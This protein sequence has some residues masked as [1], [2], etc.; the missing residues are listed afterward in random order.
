MSYPEMTRYDMN[1]IVFTCTLF[2]CLHKCDSLQLMKPPV[3]DIPGGCC[4]IMNN[5]LLLCYCSFSNQQDV[6]VQ[7]YIVI[8]YFGYSKQTEIVKTEKGTESLQMRLIWKEMKEW[9]KHWS[10]GRFFLVLVFGL[11]ASLFDFGT[12]FNFAWSVEDDC[13]F[14]ES[15]S[16][17]SGGFEKLPGWPWA[18]YA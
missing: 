4:L 6:N 12:D 17:G 8:S 3:Q 5:A 10:W 15:E 11:G 1:S 2:Y 14:E 18:F 9:R 13:G 16:E 7:L